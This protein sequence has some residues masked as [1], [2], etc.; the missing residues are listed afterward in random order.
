M[1]VLASGP[2]A[3]AAWWVSLLAAALVMGSVALVLLSLDRIRPVVVRHRPTTNEPDY[4]SSYANEP[5]PSYRLE[6]THQY[7]RPFHGVD[8]YIAKMTGASSPPP[9]EHVES[10]DWS[11]QPTAPSPEEHPWS[12]EPPVLPPT[13]VLRP[14]NPS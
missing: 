10:Q 1:Y 14:S 9:P 2:P 13:R 4:R 8:V 12:V 7:G 6:P 3:S 11:E 5:I